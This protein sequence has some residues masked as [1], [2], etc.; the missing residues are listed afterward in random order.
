MT[1]H[2]FPFLAHAR[3]SGLTLPTLTRAGDAAAGRVLYAGEEFEVTQELYDA[4]LDRINESW[5]DLT[6]E[7]QVKRWG[8]V[9]WA[10]GPKPEGMAVGGDDESF[11]Y[12][13]GLRARE[14]AKQISDPVDRARALREVDAEYSDVLNPIAQGPQFIPTSTGY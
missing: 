3:A 8:M 10:E 7:E 5:L 13:Q 14:L 1:K 12:K 6:P 2:T 11:R 4:T 9:R